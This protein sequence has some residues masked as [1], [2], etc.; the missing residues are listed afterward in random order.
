MRKEF[1]ELAEKLKKR[2]EMIRFLRKEEA[3]LKARLLGVCKNET[4]SFDGYT[5][6]RVD[7]KGPVKYSDIPELKNVDLETY[8]GDSVT[9]WKLTYEKQ[10]NELLES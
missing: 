9:S 4:T 6:L 1:V 8:R 3:D 10:F 7:R 2:Q 5:Y